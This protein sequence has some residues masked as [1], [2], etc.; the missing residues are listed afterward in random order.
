M[1]ELYFFYF[2]VVIDRYVN[3]L[4]LWNVIKCFDKIRDIYY[5]G[6]KIKKFLL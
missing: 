2:E 3:E 4:I 1:C 6:V 5:N